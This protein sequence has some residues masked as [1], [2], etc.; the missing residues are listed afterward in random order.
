MVLT[1]LPEEDAEAWLDANLPEG[2]DLEPLVTM[3]SA[4]QGGLNF[5]RSW[6][7]WALW[8]ATGDRHYRDLYREHIETHMAMPEYWAQDYY[9]FAH[10]VPQFGVYGIAA[11]YP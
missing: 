2:L 5:S 3:G 4:H 1:V 9:S 8:Q 11:S 7:L 10:W 6:G